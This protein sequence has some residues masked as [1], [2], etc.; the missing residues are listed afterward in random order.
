MSYLKSTPATVPVVQSM[1]RGDSGHFG[2]AVWTDHEYGTTVP[3][4]LSTR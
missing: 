4:T 2:K 1:W 3:M